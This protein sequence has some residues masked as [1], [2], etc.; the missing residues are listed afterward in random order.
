MVCPNRIIAAT[1]C[2]QRAKV[3]NGFFDTG[4]H[5]KAT[6]NELYIPIIHNGNI[7][8]KTIK[9]EKKPDKQLSKKAIP[10]AFQIN[11]GF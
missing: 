8:S 1:G 6:S 5:S 10:P 3:E 2:T 11:L 7:Q 9:K 4:S